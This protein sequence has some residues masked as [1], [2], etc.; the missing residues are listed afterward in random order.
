METYIVP[1]I[2]PEMDEPFGQQQRD[3][4]K[5]KWEAVDRDI[6]KL[7]ERKSKLIE[8]MHEHELSED[9]LNTKKKQKEFIDRVVAVW[10]KASS[11]CL[12]TGIAL[13]IAGFVFWYWKVQRP[14]DKIRKIQSKSAS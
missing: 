9:T 11:I 10:T 4:A 1:L 2:T 3:H 12:I 6:G 8:S 14:Q 7:E 5:M 13:C